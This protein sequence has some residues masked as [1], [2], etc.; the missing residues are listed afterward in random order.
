MAMRHSNVRSRVLNHAM[1]LLQSCGGSVPIA[2]GALSPGRGGVEWWWP[3]ACSLKLAAPLATG[4]RPSGTQSH[5]RRGDGSERFSTIARRSRCSDDSIILANPQRRPHIQRHQHLA[6]CLLLDHL[7]RGVGIHVIAVARELGRFVALSLRRCV[8][9][10]AFFVLFASLWISSG[11]RTPR[12]AR[13]F[14]LFGRQCGGLLSGRRVCRH[15]RR[16]CVRS[17]R[18][19]RK[20]TPGFLADAGRCTSRGRT[21]RRSRCRRRG[22]HRDTHGR[23]RGR[24]SARSASPS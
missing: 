18:L 5:V 3:G 16:P 7:L 13:I 6:A 20:R 17:L 22:P 14:L 21:W 23:C 24:S 10:I 4:V 12:L 8:A 1:R 11:L 9:S 2:S 15:P 19:C